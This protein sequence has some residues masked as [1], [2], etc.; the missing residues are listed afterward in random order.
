MVQRYNNKINIARTYI[1]L[2]MRGVL[3]NVLR[4]KTGGIAV[5]IYFSVIWKKFKKQS[6]TESFFGG[7]KVVRT[8][9]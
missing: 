4:N 9:E 3:I 6:H 2:L 8:S 7:N 1:F 5:K